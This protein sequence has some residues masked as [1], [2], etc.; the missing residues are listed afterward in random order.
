MTV[1]EDIGVY[2][3][4]TTR[5]GS[6]PNDFLFYCSDFI[7]NEIFYFQQDPR[8]KKAVYLLVKKGIS[9]LE[10]IRNLE[11]K[12]SIK[13]DGYQGLKDALSISFQYVSVDLER[14]KGLKSFYCF[15]NGWMVWKGNTNKELHKGVFDGN[16]FIIRIPYS[17]QTLGIIRELY[18]V[19]VFPNYFGHQRFGVTHP[20]SHELGI[21][22]I[23]G[24]LELLEKLI[25]EKNP[26]ENTWEYH[27]LTKNRIPQNILTLLLQSFQSYFFNKC[28]SILIQRNTLEKLKGKYGVLPGYDI[29]KRK[30]GKWVAEEH[31]KCIKNELK[32]WGI[33]LSELAKYK[34]IL[35][36]RIRPLTFTPREFKYVIK[37]EIKRIVIK[38]FLTPGSYASIIIREIFK[39]NEEWLYRKCKSNIHCP[40][41][42]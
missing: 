14:N 39:D 18:Q 28:L 11:V 24:E 30:Y 41:K 27:F 25:K 23:K 1:Y 2:Y 17:N 15:R 13:I 35:K 34:N 21:S 16:R 7:V 8:G 38:L 37:P 32:D 19:K 33:T 22:V 36:T 29:D 10:A 26:K 4:V 20:Y 9:T 6:N 12:Y 42:N 40:Y 5:S 3:Y 31:I